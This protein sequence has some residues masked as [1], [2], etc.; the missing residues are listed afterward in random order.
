MT[1]AK[2]R[3]ILLSYRKIVKHVLQVTLTHEVVLAHGL[4]ELED[5]WQAH[6]SVF[7]ETDID[8]RR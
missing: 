3:L 6:L 8:T 2:E 1:E 7:I 5:R 4:Q